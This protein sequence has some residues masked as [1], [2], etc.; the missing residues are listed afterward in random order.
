LNDILPC[1]KKHGQRLDSELASETGL[2]IAKVRQRLAEL[3]ATGAIITCTLT[4]FDQGKR[5]DALLCRMSGW[6]PPPVPGRKA[7][8]PA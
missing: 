2:P 3:S 4:R 5:I 8:A 6:V 7:K 1:L